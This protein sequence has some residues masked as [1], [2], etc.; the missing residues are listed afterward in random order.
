M[1]GIFFSVGDTEPAYPEE[2]TL[3]NIKNRGPD[4]YQA[5]QVTFSSQGIGEQECGKHLTFISS[6]L[7]LRGATIA[8]QPFIDPPSESVLCWNGEAWKLSNE[9]LAGNDT[10]RIFQL[11]LESIK[12]PN[13]GTL[14]CTRQVPL[15]TLAQAIST[16]AGPFAFVFYDRPWSRIIYGRDFLGRR[17]LLQGRDYKANFVISSVCAGTPSNC[18]EEVSTDGIH[19][20]DLTRDDPLSAVETIPWL[21][22][23]TSPSIYLSTP[24]PPMNQRIPTTETIT[25]LVRTLSSVVELENLL[26]QSVKLRVQGIPR[27]PSCSPGAAKV[28]V[29]FSG[30]LD[31]TVLA[32]LV[33]DLLPVDEPVDLLNIAFENPRVAAASLAKNATLNSVYEECPDRKTGRSSLAELCR[34]CPTRQWR[35]VCINIPYSETLQHRDTIRRLMRPHNTEMDLSIACA[36]YFSAR[37]IGEIAGKDDNEPPV[38]YETSARVLLS[39]LG[40][41][42]L[43]A[44]Y[45]RHALAFAR[46]GFKGLIDEIDLDVGRLGKRNLGRDDRVISNWG[47]EARYPY[48]DEAFMTWALQ[49]PVWEKCGFGIPSD[50]SEQAGSERDTHT[51]EP[52]DIEPGKKALRL[53]AWNLGMKNVARE[54]KRAI[55]FGSRT[56]KMESGRTK[57]TGVIS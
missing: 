10:Y 22:G 55:Q 48:L 2:D 20:L 45:Q 9:V 23:T 3:C 24:I 53:V 31:C 8:T 52:E 57:G 37:G 51:G 7:S 27:F 36:L 32:R 54:K 16:I 25:P 39:G 35:F 56:A 46:Q 44:G 1:C 29:L 12:P 34:V 14:P 38:S 6:V 18:F 30:G 50:A 47:R 33:H 13:N 17:S 43:F 4:S 5:H 49:R 40:A 15:G 42:E 19:V 21:H 28:A 41:D 11:F 26:R